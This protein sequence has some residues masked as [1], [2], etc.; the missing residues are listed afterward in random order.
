M[1]TWIDSFKKGVYSCSGIGYERYSYRRSDMNQ[2]QCDMCLNYDMDNETGEYYCTVNM[3][4]DEF[5]RWSYQKKTSCPYFR[6]GD[7]YTIV[8][9]QALHK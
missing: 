5:E 3:D 1:R 9:R 7:D 6:F 8:R 4:Q 2:N